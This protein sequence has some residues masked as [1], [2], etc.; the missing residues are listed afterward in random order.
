MANDKEYNNLQEPM[1]DIHIH[2]CRR[3]LG[4]R[5]RDSFDEIAGQ[6]EATFA[7]E[8][9]IEM[10]ARSN[11]MSRIPDSDFSTTEWARS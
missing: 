8:T 4:H 9:E 5:L 11:C 10:S 6:Q 3:C 1:L 7:G 2:A